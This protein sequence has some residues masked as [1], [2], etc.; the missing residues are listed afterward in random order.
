MC[1][2]GRGGGVMGCLPLPLLLLVV[3]LALALGPAAGSG[4]GPDADMDTLQDTEDQDALLSQDLIRA[5][6]LTGRLPDVSK[7]NISQEEWT[8]GHEQYLASVAAQQAS[9]LDALDAHPDRRKLYTFHSAGH[10]ADARGRHR[11]PRS[12]R[13]PV[14]TFLR[15]DLPADSV[16]DD[17]EVR[18]LV[19]QPGTV[20]VFEVWRGGRRLLAEHEATW[21]GWKRLEVL[22]AAQRAAARGAPLLLELRCAPGVR[23]EGAAANA[24]AEPGAH[25]RARRAARSDCGR[26]GTK[27]CR[28]ALQV[29]LRQIPG[30]EFILQPGSFDAGVCRGRCPPRYHP[31]N[32]H[33]LIQG[34]LRRREQRE[35]RQHDGQGQ[36]QHGDKR[37]PRVPRPCCAPARLE[38]LE[39]LRVDE[40]D[41]TKLKRAPMS[42]MRVVSCSCA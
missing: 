31:A 18:V 30:M 26:D 42:A 39:I 17:A 29:D 32:H 8:R 15:M 38:P 16:L 5:M 24:I 27:C 13:R 3:D 2:P 11:G 9:E 35:A 25:A 6:G 28:Q 19:Q 37:A 33:S 41:P 23:C 22:E 1:I 20:R 12:P 4:Y 40:N 14:R 21:P 34:L 36:A 7:V 10:H